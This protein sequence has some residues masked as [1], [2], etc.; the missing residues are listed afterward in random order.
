[1]YLKV[2]NGNEAVTYHCRQVEITQDRLGMPPAVEPPVEVQLFGVVSA[3]NETTSGDGKTTMHSKTLPNATLSI[4][5]PDDGHAI[6]CMDDR[7]RTTKI[8]RYPKEAA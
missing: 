2:E 4:R 7:R 6:Y 5:L 1:M 3:M 8:I